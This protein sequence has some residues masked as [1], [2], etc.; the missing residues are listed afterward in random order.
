MCMLLDFYQ[1][2]CF[3]T[4]PALPS[5]PSNTQSQRCPAWPSQGCFSQV[6]EKLLFFF[7]GDV[8]DTQHQHPQP[9]MTR[10]SVWHHRP[11][12]PRQGDF[13]PGHFCNLSPLPTPMSLCLW[14]NLK[15]PSHWERRAWAGLWEH[16][17]EGK[18]KMI[19]KCLLVWNTRHLSTDLLPCCRLP[20]GT[21]SSG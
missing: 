8:S 3:Q 14:V 7:Q 21:L 6:C 19:R 20:A 18:I 9:C 16:S 4:D 5:T 10:I 13:A 17:E 2:F 12:A 15:E 1:H 11:S